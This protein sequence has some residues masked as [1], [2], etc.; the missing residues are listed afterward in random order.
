MEAT[1]SFETSVDFQRTTRRYVPEDIN[2]LVSF[3]FQ[4]ILQIKI[5]I[6]Y[7]ILI[8]MLQLYRSYFHLLQMEPCL[9]QVCETHSYDKGIDFLYYLNMLGKHNLIFLRAIKNILHFISVSLC[10][11]NNLFSNLLWRHKKCVCAH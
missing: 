4:L 9:L 1:F 3:T 11:F 7:V 6:I 10:I 8:E 2:I 5:L